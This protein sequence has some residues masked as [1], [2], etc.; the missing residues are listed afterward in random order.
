MGV[1]QKTIIAH[2][3][4]RGRPRKNTTP[5][6]TPPIPEPVSDMITVAD[7]EQPSSPPTKD[8]R[9]GQQTPSPNTGS[10]TDPR[11]FMD[12]TLE[13]GG[14][15][16]SQ[17][18]S[19]V[20]PISQSVSSFADTTNRLTQGSMSE[21]LDLSHPDLEQCAFGYFDF[22]NATAKLDL[23]DQ[24]AASPVPSPSQQTIDPPAPISPR[25]H[26]PIPSTRIIGP[27][28]KEP[29]LSEAL[30]TI[31]KAIDRF[32]AQSVRFSK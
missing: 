23:S 17:S 12:P 3:R 31:Q 25:T 24:L 7:D 2:P 29:T 16:D 6:Q 18:P 10:H 26:G 28:V 15:P 8:R 21:W 5:P 14:T 13:I 4:R 30:V 1:E 20:E 27:P 22:D 19:P 9:G 32:R 11:N